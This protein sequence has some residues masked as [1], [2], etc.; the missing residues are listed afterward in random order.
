MA[1]VTRTDAERL[2]RAISSRARQVGTKANQIENKGLRGKITLSTF[3]RISEWVDIMVSKIS[4][5]DEILHEIFAGQAPESI[6]RPRA[7]R[8]PKSGSSL[9]SPGRSA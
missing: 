8:K 9:P 3:D 5:I 2:L 7:R 1:L 4:E 6:V